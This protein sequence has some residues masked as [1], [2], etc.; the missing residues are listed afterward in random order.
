MRVA[1]RKTS[2][3]RAVAYL[4]YT[5]AR[6]SGNK[7]KADEAVALFFESG[8][9]KVS[10]ENRF[11]LEFFLRIMRDPDADPRPGLSF[12]VLV[13]FPDEAADFLTPP[14][15]GTESAVVAERKKDLLRYFASE[16]PKYEYRNVRPY[17]GSSVCSA[18]FYAEYS[19]DA[20]ERK[21]LSE[22]ARTRSTDSCER[23]LRS[24]RFYGGYDVR[25]IVEICS[26][27]FGSSTEAAEYFPDSEVSF[28]AGILE[29]AVDFGT[30]SPAE[31]LEFLCGAGRKISAANPDFK[32]ELNKKITYAVAAEEISV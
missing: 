27:L 14:D 28:F 3:A 4:E 32:D 30:L 10:Y 17:G 25:R 9:S 11:D 6:A 1:N 13:R 29:E 15:K 31:T 20:R 16:S 21:L 8:L 23:L 5:E 19:K 12:P 26:I 2:K 7:N 24:H 22:L 18:L